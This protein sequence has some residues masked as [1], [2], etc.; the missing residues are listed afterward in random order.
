MNKNIF[1]VAI[2]A[3]GFIVGLAFLGNA[4][5]NRN[6]SENTISVTGLGTKQFTSD[7]ITWS[8]SFSKNNVDLKS[9]YD[10]LAMDRKVINDYLL[11]KGI[12]QKEIVFS[13]VDIQK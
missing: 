6:K 4:I 9:A 1:A 10:E 2:A 5:K 12:Q 7:L 13:S 8:G 11:S 3:L